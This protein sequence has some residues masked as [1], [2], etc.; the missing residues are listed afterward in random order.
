MFITFEGLDFSG[1]ST[2]ARLLVEK[3]RK[4]RVVHF[5]REPGGTE[6]SERI[7]EILLDKRNLEMTN[8]AEILLFSASRAQ[9][10]SQVIL[11]ALARGEVV[12]CD[13]YCDSTTAYQGYGR[14]LNLDDVRAINHMATQGRMPDVTFLVD[15]PLEEIE[16]R[17]NAASLSFDRM[18]SSG[19]PFYE[20]VR[21]GYHRLAQQESARWIVLDGTK[22]I[23]DIEKE[24][25][26]AVQPKLE[27][28]ATVSQGR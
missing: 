26:T 5:L 18:E 15:I 9:L 6:I 2:Q 11:P 7:R 10:V 12:V 20:R 3:L 4:H 23:E 25:W 17:K 21:D 14:G 19:R 24:I 27:T 22:T 16:R 1:K 28:A 13:R 8:A